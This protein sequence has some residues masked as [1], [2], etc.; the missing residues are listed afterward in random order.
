M[1]QM[2]IF[3]FPHNLLGAPDAINTLKNWFKYFTIKNH[4]I[5]ATESFKNHKG[6]PEKQTLKRL[7]WE[8]SNSLE[9]L[10]KNQDILKKFKTCT[11]IR[12]KWCIY[13]TDIL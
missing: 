6:K 8:T 12:I 5:V 1:N 2:V 10:A 4:G 7:D 3:D 13:V 11:S 9:I